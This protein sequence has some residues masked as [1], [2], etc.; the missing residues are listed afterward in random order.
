MENQLTRGKDWVESLLSLMGNS[1]PVDIDGFETIADDPDSCWLNI[2]T[3]SL[4]PEQVNSLIGEK[5]KNID[6]IQY[7]A[8]T[9]LNLLQEDEDSVQ[10]SYTIEIN[11]YRV[12]RYQELREIFDTA[13]DRVKETGEEVELAGLSS[14]ERKQVHAFFQNS[15]ELVTESRGQE[16]NRKLIVKLR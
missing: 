12:S 4:S 5:G 11:G 9:I 14:A 8:N 2:D 10:S 15:A 3:K 6:A 13:A 16:P 7:L 1:L